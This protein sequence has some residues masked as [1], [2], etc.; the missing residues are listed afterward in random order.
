MYAVRLLPLLG[1]AALALAGCGGGNHSRTNTAIK[2]G[3]T[4]AEIRDRLG[5]P[6]LV[7]PSGR[8]RCLLYPAHT[9]KA[10]YVVYCLNRAGRVQRIYSGSA[11]PPA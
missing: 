11:P 1:L 10:D 3:M 5:E 9:A 7:L 8:L 4:A 6:K 2:R